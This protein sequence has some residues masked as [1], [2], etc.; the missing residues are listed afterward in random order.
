MITGVERFTMSCDRR[1]TRCCWGSTAGSQP[2][3]EHSGNVNDLIRYCMSAGWDYAPED[4]AG[5]TCGSCTNTP[6]SEELFKERMEEIMT[7]SSVVGGV[8]F[9]A[10]KREAEKQQSSRA[11]LSKS[12]LISQ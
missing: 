3:Y 12:L 4:G 2:S 9:N 7:R 6:I 5:W 10:P 8:V 1:T 11:E